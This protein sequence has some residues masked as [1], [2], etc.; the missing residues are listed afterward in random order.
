[1]KNNVKVCDECFARICRKNVATG[2]LWIDLCSAKDIYPV[3][4]IKSDEFE[5]LRLLELMGHIVTTED[6][7]HILIRVTGNESSYFC[8]GD[9]DG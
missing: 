5:E 7:D 1:M 8:N 4:K 2:R 6:K 9:C 3:L